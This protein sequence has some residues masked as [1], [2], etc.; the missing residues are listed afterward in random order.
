MLNPVK[1]E[2]KGIWFQRSARVLF[3][4]AGHVWVTNYEHAC[5][6]S[7]SSDDEPKL[8]LT[9]CMVCRYICIP[10]CHI[11]TGFRFFTAYLDD[12]VHID[13]GPH[14]G[15]GRIEAQPA[16]SATVRE[17]TPEEEELREDVASRVVVVGP[18]TAAG[19]PVYFPKWVWKQWR[20]IL[21]Q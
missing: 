21:Q 19:G 9:P 1:T 5:G 11:K 14:A 13:V 2:G 16:V 17:H 4:R 8:T 15:G 3:S 12:P 18:A 20:A 10:L 7:P 6:H